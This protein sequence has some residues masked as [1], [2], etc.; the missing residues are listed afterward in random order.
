[1]KLK[2]DHEKLSDEITRAEL[3]YQELNEA[4]EGIHNK[5]RDAKV[6]YMCACFT[7]KHC[8]AILG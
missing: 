7:D 4:L 1:M 8:I 2:N 3:R 6:H 5:I